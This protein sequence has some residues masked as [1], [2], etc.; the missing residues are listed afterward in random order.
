[1]DKLLNAS[2]E[3]DPIPMK[4]ES[5][6]QFFDPLNDIQVAFIKDANGQ[7]SEMT[8]RLNGREFHGKKIK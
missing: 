6:T 4:P 5:E 2:G 1:V 8:L 3:Q 7:I